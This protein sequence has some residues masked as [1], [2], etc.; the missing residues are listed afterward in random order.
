MAE[1]FLALLQPVVIAV[2]LP[3]PH[4]STRGRFA[5]A[6]VQ[7]DDDRLVTIPKA[8]GQDLLKVSGRG[9]VRCVSLGAWRCLVVLGGAWLCFL[10][11]WGVRV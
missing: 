7:G 10:V 9:V 4:R 2:P 11:R 1:T 8:S 5:V 3:M 6:T